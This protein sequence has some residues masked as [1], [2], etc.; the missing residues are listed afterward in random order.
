VLEILYWSPDI[1]LLEFA[2]SRIVPARDI[3][4]V[5]LDNEHHEHE[6]FTVVN[7]WYI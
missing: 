2:I 6:L 5:G 3:R 4:Q 7:L 1:A